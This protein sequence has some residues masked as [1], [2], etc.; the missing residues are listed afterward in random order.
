MFY[1]FIE[2]FC[3][4]SPLHL[5]SLFPPA[6]PPVFWSALFLCYL[7]TRW[8][9]VTRRPKAAVWV[10]VPSFGSWRLELLL[11]TFGGQVCDFPDDRF[12]GFRA[13]TGL[14]AVRFL[15]PLSLSLSS[16]VIS[17]PRSFF[18]WFFSLR[19]L[20]PHRPLFSTLRFSYSNSGQF[21][22]WGAVYTRFWHQTMDQRWRAI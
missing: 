17:D 6:L 20:S 22:S 19:C 10:V 13:A 12:R 21:T 16:P 2:Q 18:L 1:D 11:V 15:D 14:A 4:F 5:F 9:T 8:A 3:F 7:K